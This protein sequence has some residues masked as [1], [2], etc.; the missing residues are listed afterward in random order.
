MYSTL[1]LFEFLVA[2]NTNM[3]TK[4]NLDFQFKRYGRLKFIYEMEKA[5]EVGWMEHA[6]LEKDAKRPDTTG[7]VCGLAK[8][9]HLLVS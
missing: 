8:F 5:W 9:R 3:Q 2:T 7:Q 1:V 6:T 4:Y